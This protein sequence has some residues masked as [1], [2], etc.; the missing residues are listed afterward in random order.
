MYQHTDCS[1]AFKGISLWFLDA[2]VTCF[3]HIGE[4]KE[5][6][7][8]EW[9]FPRSLSL[10]RRNFL[11]WTFPSWLFLGF[12]IDVRNALV[13]FVAPRVWEYIFM[14]AYK[15]PVE[16]LESFFFMSHQRAG[17]GIVVAV[18]YLSTIRYRSVLEWV[19][20]NRNDPHRNCT[21]SARSSVG[22]G[23]V[24]G[25]PS[26]FAGIKVWMAMRC[27]KHRSNLD[28]IPGRKIGDWFP[29]KIWSCMFHC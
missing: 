8:L 29:Q 14:S 7:H 3:V 11:F 4:V 5:L 13:I 28:S 26:I 19:V 18:P 2:Y 25:Y 20:G 6:G 16:S 10:Q 17:S 1:K 9:N 27:M 12:P 23:N 22:N 15:H 21:G 24:V